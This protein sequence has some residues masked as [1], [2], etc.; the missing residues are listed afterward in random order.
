M[1][2]QSRKMLIKTQDGIGWLKERHEFSKKE[3]TRLMSD[4]Q[5]NEVLAFYDGAISKLTEEINALPVGYRCEGTFYIRKPY[6]MP[7]EFMKVEGAIFMRED[8]VKWKV[9]N[10]DENFAYS[11]YDKVY[12]E[13]CLDA[14]IFTRA[15]AHPVFKEKYTAIL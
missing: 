12:K 10:D 13:P 9:E 7:V 11:Y 2:R 5:Y 8:L 6:S 4:A 15:D 3:L 1:V 14:D